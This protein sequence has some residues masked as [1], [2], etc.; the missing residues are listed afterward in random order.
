MVNKYL[1]RVAQ[2]LAQKW[3]K[4]IDVSTSDVVESAQSD[5]NAVMYKPPT[6]P[7]LLERFREILKRVAAFLPS[8]YAAQQIFN[9]IAAAK[10]K[11]QLEQNPYFQ[12]AQR[13]FIQLGFLEQ[14]LPHG[15]EELGVKENAIPILKQNLQTLMNGQNFAG[16]QHY[17]LLPAG[18]APAIDLDEWQAGQNKNDLGF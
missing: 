18:E 9:N 11:N 12:E 1:Q 16:Y 3:S 15:A 10:Q 13:I 7:E 8:K 5:D 17:T 2:T 4:D 6:P 14:Q